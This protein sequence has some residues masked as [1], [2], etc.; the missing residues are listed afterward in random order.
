MGGEGEGAS[1][2]WLCPLT[3]ADM[4]TLRVLG[5]SHVPNTGK[6]SIEGLEGSTHYVPCFLA[7]QMLPWKPSEP[8]P[9]AQLQPAELPASLPLS[10]SLHTGNGSAP[11]AASALGM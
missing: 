7:H 5:Y 10:L 2:G 8:P 1:L 9:Q 6:R 4:A 11:L 3:C